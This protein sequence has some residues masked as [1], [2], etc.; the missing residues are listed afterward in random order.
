MRLFHVEFPSHPRKPVS[1]FTAAVSSPPR[2]ASA[3]PSQLTFIF[4]DGGHCL[5]L[6]VLPWPGFLLKALLRCGGCFRD[7]RRLCSLLLKQECHAHLRDPRGQI[8]GFSS[9]SELSL[10]ISKVLWT[11]LCFPKMGFLEP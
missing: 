4:T 8:L 1:H 6:P 9:Q 10:D 5:P 7:E 3:L 11:E 2:P